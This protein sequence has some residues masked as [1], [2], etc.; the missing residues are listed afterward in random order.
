[1]LFLLLFNLKSTQKINHAKIFLF[2][3]FSYYTQK[4]KEEENEETFLLYF[5]SFGSHGVTAYGLLQHNY[6]SK[7]IQEQQQ[8]RLTLDFC[9]TEKIKNTTKNKAADIEKY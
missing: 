5:L 6:Q 9:F 7:Y 2:N 3:I 8:P 4:L 1:M